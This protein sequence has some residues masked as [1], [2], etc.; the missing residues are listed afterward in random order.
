MLQ[1]QYELVI[2]QFDTVRKVHLSGILPNA[3]S[4]SEYNTYV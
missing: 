3:T 2:R 4:T 1:M